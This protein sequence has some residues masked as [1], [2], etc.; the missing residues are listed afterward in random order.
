[1]DSQDEQELVRRAMSIIGRAKTPAKIAS[2]R[3]AAEARKGKPLSPEHREA[4]RQGQ[5]ARRQREAAERAKTQQS[6]D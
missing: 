3:A 6:G 1:M 4:L 5:I 2:A